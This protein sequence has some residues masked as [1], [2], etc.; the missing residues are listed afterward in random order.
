[1]FEIPPSKISICQGRVLDS[2]HLAFTSFMSSLRAS[3]S[4]FSCVRFTAEIITNLL[5]AC[6]SLIHMYNHP[7]S[8]MTCMTLCL[9]DHYIWTSLGVSLFRVGFS[10]NVLNQPRFCDRATATKYM[11]CKIIY[12][13]FSLWPSFRDQ[14]MLSPRLMHALGLVCHSLSSSG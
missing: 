5:T 3:V 6:S 12:P 7:V 1:M 11:G 13:R 14:I 9:E 10:T 4:S 8:L 2:Q